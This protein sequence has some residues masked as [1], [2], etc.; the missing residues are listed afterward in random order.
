MQEIKTTTA[1]TP[2]IQHTL[3]PQEWKEWGDFAERY[4]AYRRE[5][6]IYYKDHGLPI[7][8]FFISMAFFIFSTE[9]I[10]LFIAGFGFFFASV[11]YAFID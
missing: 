2:P 6:N 5:H 10:L 3:S 1:T 8:L 9:D 4:S 11:Y 7:I